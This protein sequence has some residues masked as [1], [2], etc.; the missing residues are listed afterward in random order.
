MNNYP[1]TGPLQ[2]ECTGTESGQHEHGLFC[3]ACGAVHV[4][5]DQCCCCCGDKI[6]GHNW[7]NSN[8]N[9]VCDEMYYGSGIVLM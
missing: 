1:I 4:C 6:E 9:P 8:H 7:W 2:D 3:S 5:D